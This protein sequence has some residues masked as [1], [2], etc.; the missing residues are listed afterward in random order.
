MQHDGPLVVFRVQM[1]ADAATHSVQR[2]VLASDPSG[3]RLF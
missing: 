1:A 2:P 3:K